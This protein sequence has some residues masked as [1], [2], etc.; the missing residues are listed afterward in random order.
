MPIYEYQ[1]TDCGDDFE[2]F[3]R[4]MFSQEKITCP[5]CGSEQVKKAFSLFGATSSSSGS[6][7]SAAA[8]GPV[9]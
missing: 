7:S 5:T 4:S 1:C 9:G 3:L 2:R 6:V 8:C